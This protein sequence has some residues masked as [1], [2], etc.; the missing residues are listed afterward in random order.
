MPLVAGANLNG[1]A[2]GDRR[3]DRVTVR[4]PIQSEYDR[5]NISKYCVVTS[6]TAPSSTSNVKQQTE[7]QSSRECGKV[8]LFNG[9]Q[10]AYQRL[11]ATL[12][13]VKETLCR[14]HMF[15]AVSSANH[16]GY[17]YRRHASQHTDRDPKKLS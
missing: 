5:P 12:Q 15:T 8:A 7:G 17:I 13:D 6:F 11:G 9:L 2:S 1:T 14:A 3:S 16:R 4:S 10:A